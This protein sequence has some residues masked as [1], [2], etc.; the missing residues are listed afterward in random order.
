MI[1]AT[2]IWMWMVTYEPQPR[3]EGITARV[4]LEELVRPE[5]ARKEA[6]LR[7]FLAMGSE[8]G[9]V[10]A[11]ALSRRDSLVQR[12]LQWGTV[13]LGTI[14][15]GWIAPATYRK[16]SLEVLR[17]MGPEARSAVPAVIRALAQ[18]IEPGEAQAFQE[19]LTSMDAAVL[20]E[21]LD[22]VRQT[23][24]ILVIRVV[25]ATWKELLAN[26]VLEADTL[27]AVR[28]SA[29]GFLT[30]TDDPVVMEAVGVIARMRSEGAAAIPHLIQVFQRPGRTTGP[31]AERIVL[32]LGRIGAEPHRVV[33]VLMKCVVGGDT[34]VRV[35]AVQALGAF[36]A[37]AEEAVPVLEHAL[38]DA[39]PYVRGRA[40]LAL[41][42]IGAAAVP[43][44]GGLASALSDQDE[45][46]Q[47]AAIEALGAIGPG[48]RQAVPQLYQAWSNKQSGLGRHVLAAL[49]RIEA[50][51]VE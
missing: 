44:V 35:A 25:L 24:E 36:G 9:P 20:R 33:P 28:S 22:V 31:V 13:K 12:V 40:A 21:L 18:G 51:V 29:I 30:S 48:A 27:V 38:G 2:A 14:Q 16:E 37:E 45:S 17:R 26:G 8:G 6:A 39:D 50:D 15:P 5:R 11:E 19:I 49:E 23:E 7:A 32:T 43:A 1:G 47:V 10:L 3:H 41:G 4:W 42:Q 46:V 34:R